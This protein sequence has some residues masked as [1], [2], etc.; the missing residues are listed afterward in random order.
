MSGTMVG[1]SGA[2]VDDKRLAAGLPDAGRQV[3]KLLALGVG[4]A[5]DMDMPC[6]HVRSSRAWRRNPV[7]FLEATIGSDAL[8]FL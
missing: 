8:V 4:R 3:G 2:D 5:D 7:H 1:S 6:R